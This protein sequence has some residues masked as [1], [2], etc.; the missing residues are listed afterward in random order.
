MKNI[1]TTQGFKYR[2]ML[3]VF[4][5]QKQHQL[6]HMTGFWNSSV[7]QTPDLREVAVKHKH[8]LFKIVFRSISKY[9]LFF[10]VVEADVSLYEIFREVLGELKSIIISE[11][12]A[13]WHHEVFS[14]H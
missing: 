14:E 13:N 8:A 10:G 7:F 12:C 1:S 11:D 5:K 2:N 9:V 4:S 3:S 6:N